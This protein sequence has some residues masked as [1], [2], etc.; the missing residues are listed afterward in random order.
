MNKNSKRKQRL[1]RKSTRTGKSSIISESPYRN[2]RQVVAWNKGEGE[3]VGNCSLT[4]HEVIKKNE[5]YL[6]KGK[7]STEE[8]LGKQKEWKF[9]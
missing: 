7:V 1:N 9:N 8:T 3:T 4:R 6:P 2:M 5:K